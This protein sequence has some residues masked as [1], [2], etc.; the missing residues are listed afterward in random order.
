[1]VVIFLPAAADS[2]VLQERI[3]LPS[4]CTVQAPHSAAPQPNLVPV[5]P[6]VSRITQSSGVLGSA[7]TSRVLPLMSRLAMCASLKSR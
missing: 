4:R 1:M 2:G 7:S 5:M 3:G 6:S